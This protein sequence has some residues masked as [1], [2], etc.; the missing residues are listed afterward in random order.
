[1]LEKSAAVITILT[2][3]VNTFV[4]CIEV[5]FRSVKSSEGESKTLFYIVERFVKGLKFCPT[6]LKF[7]WRESQD[8]LAV[9]K[10]LWVEPKFCI[11]V[12]KTLRRVSQFSLRV[13]KYLW[14]E[15]QFSPNLDKKI[16]TDSNFCLE[17]AKFSCLAS[18]FCLTVSKS[19]RGE[20]QFCIT[21]SKNLWGE[22][23]F[24][25]TVLE[26]NMAL[27]TN[28]FEDVKN[29]VSWIEVLLRSV[30]ISERGN[31]TLFHS[32]VKGLSRF[33]L[34]LTVLGILWSK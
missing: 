32:V 9:S 17:V 2:H 14:D 1:M 13:S 31:K 25:H 33:K 3:E 28:L 27:I 20:R 30:N 21:V 18:K 6:V 26:E 23:P 10:R 19:L 8:C 11:A 29:F 24:C 7:L 4:S 15:L 12:P 16:C 34:L 5:L 22:L